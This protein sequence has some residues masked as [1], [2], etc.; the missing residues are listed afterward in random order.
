M[1][2]RCLR[3]L[4]LFSQVKSGGSDDNDDDDRKKKIGEKEMAPNSLSPHVRSLF[5]SLVPCVVSRSISLASSHALSGVVSRFLFC[6]CVSSSFIHSFV[7]DARQSLFSWWK[8]A[9]RGKREEKGGE[10]KRGKQ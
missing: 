6:C 5:H 4:S 9:L 3:C 7:F 1:C 8:N 2:L 10:K